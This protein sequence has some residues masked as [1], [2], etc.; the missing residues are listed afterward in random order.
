MLVRMVAVRAGIC[1]VFN[2]A[3]RTDNKI[4]ESRC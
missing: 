3:Q 2:L 4:P 1:Q